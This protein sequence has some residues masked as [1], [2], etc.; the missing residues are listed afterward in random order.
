MS[1]TPQG[2]YPDPSDPNVLRWWDGS[3][4][5]ANTQPT[6]PQPPQVP[7]APQ[8]ARYNTSSPVDIS[9]DYNMAFPM[10][11]I[12]MQPGNQIR[13][14]NGSMVYRSAGVE[15][16]TRLNAKGSGIGKLASAV[17]RSITSGESMFITEVVCNE[18]NGVIAIAPEMPG[19]IKQ[20]DIGPAQYRLNDSVFLAMDGSVNYTMQR[21][22]VGKAFLSGTGGF[23]VMSTEGSGRLLINSYGSIVELDLQ[24]AS[25][26]AID[27]G[28]VVAWE[29]SLQYTINLQSGFWGSIGTGEGVVNTFSGTGKVLIQTLNLQSLAS[30]LVPFLPSK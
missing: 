27:N 30:K 14:A 23:F 6:T 21:Q 25:G 26:F 24:N 17:G 13:I 9:I 8:Q 4:W 3:Q 16:N 12:T 20:L 22:S 5:T 2:W 1:N 7:Q 19:T 18:P 15:L 10:A 28:H 11:T 29:Q